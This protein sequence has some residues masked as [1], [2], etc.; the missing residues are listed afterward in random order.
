M[1]NVVIGLFVLLFVGCVNR[2]NAAWNQVELDPVGEYAEIETTVSLKALENLQS[3]NRKVVEKTLVHIIENPGKYVP[4]VLYCISNYLFLMGEKERAPF[5]F[6]LG[7]LR[8]IYDA[9]RCT[10]KSAQ[11]AVE[12]LNQ[13]FGL[14][15]NEYTFKNLD[16]LKETVEKVFKYDAEIPYEYDHRWINLYGSNAMRASLSGESD[17]TKL[18]L[19]E[20]DWEKIHA[21]TRKNYKEG[22]ERAM[23]QLEKE[24]E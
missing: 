2:N 21:D 12:V 1:R 17:T 9:N 5:Y 23:A 8:A 11:S 4:P 7:Q 10:D 20:S 14:I 15:I 18:S 3:R 22:F 19:P 13:E 16:L 24:S 6:Y